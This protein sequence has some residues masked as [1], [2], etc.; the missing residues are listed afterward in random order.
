[1]RERIIL[2]TLKNSSGYLNIDYFADKLGVSTR[3]I[4]NEIKDRNYKRM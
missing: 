2:E 1:M 4:R 3:T